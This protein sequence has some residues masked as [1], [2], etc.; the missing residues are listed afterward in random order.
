M[1]FRENL[2]L[3]QIYFNNLRT[4]IDTLKAWRG[5]EEPGKVKDILDS[6]IEANAA[7]ILLYKNL[8]EEWNELT[9]LFNKN[10]KDLA[11]L[12]D[13]LEEYHGELNDK[14]D[15]VNNY[16]MALIRDLETRMDAAE[17]RLDAIEED[18]DSLVRN[19]LVE[20]EE[21]GGVYSLTYNGEPVDF[22]T[23]A[24]WMEHPH[25]I[26]IH[27]TIDGEDVILT[28][29]NID[30]TPETGSIEW[31]QVGAVNDTIHDITLSLLPDDSVNVSTKTFDIGDLSTRLSAAESDIETLADTKQDKL[32]AGNGILIDQNNE[33]SVD[34]S[35]VQEKLTAGSGI[36]IDPDTNEISATGGGG[37]SYTAG[38]GINIDQ[39]NEISVDT[40]VV[41]EKLT[42]GSGIAIDSNT[43]TISLDANLSAL[44]YSQDF[45]FTAPSWMSITL[46]TTNSE[47]CY[48]HFCAQVS[49]YLKITIQGSMMNHATLGNISATSLFGKI[50]AGSIGPRFTEILI[51]GRVTAEPSESFKNYN[52]L[53]KKIYNAFEVQYEGEV[54]Q[55]GSQ[56]VYYAAMTF[57][58]PLANGG[59]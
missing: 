43:N 19:Y 45:G 22:E 44:Q 56:N 34:T 7:I 3:E 27:G 39:N 40:S 33:I 48:N 23:V 24:E 6:C 52:L 41:Q 50:L 20:L 54:I 25:V 1:A 35:V 46:E 18:L 28:E 5:T 53:F 14:I 2:R 16:L 29:R 11:D 8:G 47:I 38:N 42:A 26:W 4:L 30:T 15:E 21:D 57:T 31:G 12:K 58:F 51:P 36:S 13:L 17:A 37:A 59:V 10:A 32:T 55:P 49:F 9:A